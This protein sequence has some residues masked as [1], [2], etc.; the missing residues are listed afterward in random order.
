MKGGAMVQNLTSYTATGTTGSV[1]WTVTVPIGEDYR[2]QVVSANEAQSAVSASTFH[3]TAASG[4][5]TDNT[6]L[7]AGAVIVV[8]A[9]V[10][11]AG[12]FLL[13]KKKA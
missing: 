8:V 12:Y 1:A 5:T 11:V 9:I 13:R 3:V 6:A 10:V 4:S 2:V 7:I